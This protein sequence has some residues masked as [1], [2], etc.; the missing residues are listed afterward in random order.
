MTDMT[1]PTERYLRGKRILAAVEKPTGVSVLDSVAEFAPDME[2]LV[3]EFGYADVF[4]RPGLSAR[5]RQLV[6]LAALGALGNAP[7]QLRFHIGGALNVGCTPTEVV[8][9]FIHLTLYAGI[10]AALNAMG[11]AREVF[12]ARDLAAEPAAH[13][14]PPD[15]RYA[16]GAEYLARVDGGAGAGV[17]ASLADIAPDLGRFIM[18]YAFG[19]IYSRP[20]LA[21]R[22][23]ELATVAACAAL[24]TVHPQ[25]AVHTHGFLNV[26]GT[27]DELIEIAIQT[28]VYAGFPAALNA[29]ATIRAV[30][31]DGATETPRDEGSK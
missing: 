14:T 5:D 27:V 13:Q 30:I 26:G 23:R 15:Q 22:D 16:T 8:E 21:L 19:D 29:L 2:R 18:E 9:T 20:G 12:G 3:V 4:A 28:A 11:A 1:A 17:I 10:P 6:T 24:G 7:S 25:L 31:E